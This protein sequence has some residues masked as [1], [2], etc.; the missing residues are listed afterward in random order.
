MSDLRFNDVVI[1]STK[2]IGPS[3]E[4]H[5]AVCKTCS[6]QKTAEIGEFENDRL[7]N[8]DGSNYNPLLHSDNSDQVLQYVAEMRVWNCCHEGQEP[9]DGFPEDPR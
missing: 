9:I 8:L 2:M 5:T 6:T 3:G 7:H 1:E 4:R